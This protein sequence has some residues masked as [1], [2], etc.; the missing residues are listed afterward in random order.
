MPDNKIAKTDSQSIAA[1]NE[2]FQEEVALTNER[3]SFI[4]EGDR[5]GTEDIGIDD[6]RMPRLVIAQGLS[7][8]MTPGDPAHI[9]G[10]TMFDMFNS[11]T[12]QIY[13]KGPIYFV[14]VKRDTRRIEFKP[15]IEG[16][17][18]VD[19]DVPKGDD[20]LKWH[21]K[22]PPVATTFTEFVS[23]L[24]KADGVTEPIV[25]SVKHTNK[26]NTNAAKDLNGFISERGRMRGLP[27]Y[28]TI[29]SAESVGVR[30]DKGT[31]GVPS[32]KPVR[33]LPN[34]DAGRK[35]YEE[36]ASYALQ[37]TGKN[38]IIDREPGDE[39]AAA[40]GTVEGEVVGEKA[41]F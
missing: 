9:P 34:T 7:P 31:F 22:I 3:P 24:L 23:L 17:G 18:V 32:F 4:A 19:L 40:D 37:L 39:D 16:G 28:S 10:L 1:L 25:I 20:R 30:N 33:T 2:F 11:G 12:K 8:E 14:V 36:A 5:T 26:H 27:I 6:V 13:G 21:G 29:Y 41:P 15:R 35:L 38:I